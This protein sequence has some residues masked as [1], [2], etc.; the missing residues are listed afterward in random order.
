M[1]LVRRYYCRIDKYYRDTSEVLMVRAILSFLSFLTLSIFVSRHAAIDLGLP[2]DACWLVVVDV[3]VLAVVVV[4]FIV[5]VEVVLEKVVEAAAEAE[6][7]VRVRWV[8][9]IRC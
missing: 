7:Q 9:L 3:A 5:V 8:E 2:L 6:A 1:I 4:A